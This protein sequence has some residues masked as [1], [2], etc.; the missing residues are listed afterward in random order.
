MDFDRILKNMKFFPVSP[1]NQIPPMQVTIPAV[2][3]NKNIE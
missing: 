3:L 2:P 1:E